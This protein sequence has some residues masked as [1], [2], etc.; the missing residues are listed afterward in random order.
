MN[1]NKLKNILALEMSILLCFGNL[2]F[3]LTKHSI[4]YFF[5]LHGTMILFKHRAAAYKKNIQLKAPLI[6]YI[7]A[8]AILNF[9]AICGIISV[10]L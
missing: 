10:F 7:L 3:V 6:L 9:M 2:L 5:T 8:A 1:K 4:I